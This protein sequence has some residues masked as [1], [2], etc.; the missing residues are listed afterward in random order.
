MTYGNKLPEQS[1]KRQKQHEGMLPEIKPDGKLNKSFFRWQHLRRAR[2]RPVARDLADAPGRR[3]AGGLS[4]VISAA[5][6]RLVELL[7]FR[8]LPVIVSI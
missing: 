6:Q 4:P 1:W 7:R 2:D 5:L 8:R 3:R